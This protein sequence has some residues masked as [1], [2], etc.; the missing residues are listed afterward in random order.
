M[1]VLRKISFCMTARETALS[2]LL[3]SACFQNV[4]I[5]SLGGAAIKPF[6][7][8]A[9][10]LLVLSIVALRT[11][12]SLF[13]R[14]FLIS[15]LYVIGISLIDSMRFGINV[16]LFNYAF[17]FVMIASVMNYGRGLPMDRWGVIVRSSALFVIA[18][19]RLCSTE[20]LLWGLFLMGV[21]GTLPSRPFLA[22]ALIWRHHG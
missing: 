19:V 4:V 20:M 10:I 21:M 17:F 12:W 7:V 15:V 11:S 1:R 8:I 14:W 22:T 18:V 13:N 6:H 2:A 16:V 3:I 5:F 9:L